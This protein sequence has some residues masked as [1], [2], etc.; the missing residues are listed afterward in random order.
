MQILRINF[1]GTYHTLL[2]LRGFQDTGVSW[3]GNNCAVEVDCEEDGN[4][5]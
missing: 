4:E 3:G 2:V 5:C 1:N